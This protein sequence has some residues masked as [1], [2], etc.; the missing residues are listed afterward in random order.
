MVNIS[1]KR[2]WPYIVFLLV[3]LIVSVFPR[4][5]FM[6][7]LSANWRSDQTL[8]T[9]FWFQK[10]GISLFHSQLPLYGPP[11]EVPFEFPV[12]Q[13]ISAIFSN[14][15]HLNLTASSRVVS[16]ASFYLSAFFLLLLCLEFL[17]NRT[18]SAII[19]L[20][21][22]YLPY[23]IRYSTEILIDYLS[24]ALALGYIFCIKKF[25]DSPRNYL[26]CILAIIFGC[27]GAVVKITTMA[28]IIIPAILITLDGFQTWGIKFED[29]TAPKEII[30]KI[31]R[32]KLSFLLLTAIVLLPILSAG[33]WTN[34]TDSIKQSN[35]F[36]VWLTSAN[37]TAWN[38]GT[39]DQKISFTSW[40][41]WLTKINNQFFLGGIL[42]LFPLLGIVFLYKMPLKSRGFF[43]AALTGTLFAIFIFFNLFLHE[44]YYIA[45]S[46]YVS[47][48]IGFGIFCLFKF[49]LPHKIW[50]I[51]FG[52]IFFLFIFM[53]GLEQYRV[54]QAEVQ[55][56]VDYVLTKIIPLA[57]RVAATTPEDKYIISFQSNWYPDFILYTK[58][59]GLVISPV[60]DSKFSCELINKYDYSTIVIVDRPPDTPELLG[61]FNCFK[62]VQLIK[63]GIYKIN[64]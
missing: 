33:L 46:A 18:L 13:A 14:I 37:L 8:L 19:F 45:V 26:L 29:L 17:N 59:K 56:E 27:L 42:L 48:L 25:W 31:G 57:N 20:V 30:A 63:P 38:F 50:W 2:D 16:A 40:W 12:Y 28:I 62:S 11:W 35:I 3:S 15:T 4:L 34:F 22:L 39:L 55:A 6:H 60:E 53:K 51:V 52:G 44:Y 5:P 61:I 24:V 58:R 36:T 47:V 23:D 41:N 1:L 9:S 54:K 7:R 32:Q 64:P 43:G 10:E 49:L 21:Y